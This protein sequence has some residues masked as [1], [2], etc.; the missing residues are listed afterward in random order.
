MNSEEQIRKLSLRVT[1][2][3]EGSDAFGVAMNELRTGIKDS[4]RCGRQKI[5]AMKSASLPSDDRF[6]V[7]AFTAVPSRKKID[8]AKAK[9]SLSTRCPQ[10]DH[11]VEPS[12]LQ[13]IDAD[14]VRC[15]KCLAT[16]SPP[17]RKMAE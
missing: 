6:T 1:A 8:L 15:P 9:A 14:R 13:R 2:A 5:G 10:C 3:P 16:V 7:R 4:A 12:E 11:T 17:H